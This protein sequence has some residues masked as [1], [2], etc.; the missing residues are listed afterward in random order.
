MLN[1]ISQTQNNLICM[2]GKKRG[3]LPGAEGLRVGGGKRE[4]VGER[5]QIFSYKINKLNFTCGSNLMAC[6]K[7]FERKDPHAKPLSS[8]TEDTVM[9]IT[10][11]STAGRCSRGHRHKR[12]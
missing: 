8:I 6:V 9:I 12:L 4:Y 10:W 2:W 7:G 3:W 11:P 1:K 5:V